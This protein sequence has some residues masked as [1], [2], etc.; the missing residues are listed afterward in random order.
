MT[1]AYVLRPNCH[2]INRINTGNLL[3]ATQKDSRDEKVKPSM[4]LLCV[5]EDTC[6]DNRIFFMF[7]SVC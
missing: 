1:Y 7:L 5:S 6:D 2:I 4:I 3:G